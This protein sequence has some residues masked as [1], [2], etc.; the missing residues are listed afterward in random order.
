[1][2]KRGKM[3]NKIDYGTLGELPKKVRFSTVDL[4]LVFVMGLCAGALLVMFAAL[5]YFGI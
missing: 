2:Q 4:A 3:K 1:M 5:R